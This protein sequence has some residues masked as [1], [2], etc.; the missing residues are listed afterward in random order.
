MYIESDVLDEYGLTQDELS[1]HLGVSR[2]TVSEIINGRRD[3]SASIAVRL[4]ALTGTSPDF[5]LN[6]QK[7]N[8]VYRAMKADKEFL[9]AITPLFK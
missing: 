4:S 7:E 6:I 5:W 8:D 2:R 9:M 1:I 3:L